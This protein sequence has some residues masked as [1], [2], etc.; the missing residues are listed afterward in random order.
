MFHLFRRTTFVGFVTRHSRLLL[1]LLL[2]CSF[3][4][5]SAW[6][7]FG[8]DKVKIDLKKNGDAAVDVDFDKSR[9]AAGQSQDRTS[10]SGRNDRQIPT[11]KPKANLPPD[12][13]PGVSDVDFS[14]QP[15]MPS[16]LWPSLLDNQ[17]WTF[18]N[19]TGR[20]RIDNILMG[21]LPQTMKDGTPIN[22]RNV[23]KDGMMVWMD[24]VDTRTGTAVGRAYYHAEV[25]EMPFY[26]LECRDTYAPDIM[27]VEGSYELRFFVGGTHVSTFPFSVVKDVTSDPYSPVPHLYFLQGAWQDWAWIEYNS[28]DY[29][30]FVFQAQDRH[31]K[32]KNQSR[33][34]VSAFYDYMVTLY[35]GN[36]VI[37]VYNVEGST[38]DKQDWGTYSVDNGIWAPISTAF[39][40]HSSLP[41][42]KGIPDRQYVTK[43][44]LA[45][46]AYRIVLTHR[47]QKTKK[48][49]SD[50]YTFTISGGVIQ[51]HPATDRSKVSDVRTLVEQGAKY[52]MIHRQ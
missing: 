44:D 3:G 21:F 41:S 14:K 31:L 19:A 1:P 34:D 24:V 30:N 7:Q 4:T 33:T 26:R 36:K 23:R 6:A 49:W 9:D 35:R 20:L 11:A 48:Q 38:I 42:M 25:H 28:S 22:Y 12:G 15:F 43:D 50:T 5:S 37:G 10:S 29:L 17:H 47:D 16:V 8:L 13:P 46:G 40:R 2:C 39:F 18:L 52:F 45:D 32:V 27:L 51:Q